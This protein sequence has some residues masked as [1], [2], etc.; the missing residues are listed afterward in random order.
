MRRKNREVTD[1]HEILGIIEKS[2]VCRVAFSDDNMPYIVPM[3]FGYTY[4]NKKL[5][6]YF[7]SAFEGKKIDLLRKNPNVCF[8][9]DCY[10]NLITGERA[11]N[12]TAE[13]ES[14]IGFG[15]IKELTDSKEKEKGLLALMWT[16]DKDRAFDFTQKELD[17]VNVLKL[18]VSEFTGKRYRKNPA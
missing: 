15:T 3:N 4:E 11:C 17:S 12:Y 2:E 14:V 8:E 1:I 10:H 5:T 18:E 13:F 6:L 7:H 9:F 16:Y